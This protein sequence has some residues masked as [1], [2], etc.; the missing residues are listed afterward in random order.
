[1]LQVNEDNKIYIETPTFQKQS[2]KIWSEDERLD[3]ISWIAVNPLAGDVIP[4]AEGAR[5]VRWSI[6]GSGKRGGARIIYFNQSEQGQ[7]ILITIYKKSEP[8]NISRREI[9]E[10][11]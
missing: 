4:N 7:I 9:K 11:K 8:E 1:M 5:K 10:A 6:K 3:F 2:E